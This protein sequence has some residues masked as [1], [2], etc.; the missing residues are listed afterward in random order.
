[1]TQYLNNRFYH[2]QN[3]ESKAVTEVIN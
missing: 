3:T 1:V 2:Y